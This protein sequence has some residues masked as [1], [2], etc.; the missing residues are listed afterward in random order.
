MRYT[1]IRLVLAI[2][3][4]ITWAGTPASAQMPQPFSVST[5]EVTGFGFVVSEPG[6]INITAQWQGAPLV[7]RL[8][9]PLAQPIEKFG[10]GRA[11]ITYTVTADDVRRGTIWKVSLRPPGTQAQTE[12]E[13]CLTTSCLSRGATV[14]RRATGAPIVID[15]AR[16]A[17]LS[18]A[19]KTS[20]QGT[21]VIQHPAGDVR[22]AE[23]Q[24][25][26]Q[27]EQQ[28]ASAQAQEVQ[29]QRQHQGAVEQ[30][31]LQVL[32]SITDQQSA[33]R[34]QLK[35]QAMAS[36][37]ATMSTQSAQ[38]ATNQPITQRP[39]RPISASQQTTATTQS[40]EIGA[41]GSNPPQQTV[42]APKIASLSVGEGQPGDPVTINGSAFGS[43]PGEVHF[44]VNPGMDVKAN[45]DY[46]GDTQIVI[47][48]PSA[49]K[50]Q[51][52]NGTVYIQRGTDKTNAVSFKFNPTLDFV[53]LTI[54]N[55]KL[56]KD[57]HDASFE[58]SY[59]R[60]GAHFGSGD[61]FGHKDDDQF[62][63]NTLLKNGWVVDSVNFGVVY[64]SGNANAGVSDNRIGTNSPFVKVHWWMDAFSAVTYKLSVTIKGPKGIPYQ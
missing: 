23:A 16:M 52:Y 58:S 13:P 57:P 49:E 47:S 37:P 50:I 64:I 54:T 2:A 24:L 14:R 39:T 1:Q 53:T 20:A 8:T 51:A 3:L 25:K 40:S 10:S 11:Q 63:M 33:R 55:D 22:Q 26:G 5:G 6:P 43:A 12:D 62:F 41:A 19:P 61:F 15:S 27:A 9:G 7:L 44:I 45:A 28:R 21:I 60:A 31:K 48:V 38:I 29:I 30:R 34:Q 35:R 32:K 17:T 59:G 18:R 46:W 4:A 36:K 42:A 56:I